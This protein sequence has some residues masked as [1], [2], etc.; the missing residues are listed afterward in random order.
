MRRG[1]IHC[2]VRG[3][4]QSRVRIPLPTCQNEG[5]PTR[6][7]DPNQTIIS[8]NARLPKGNPPP[9]LWP[10]AAGCEGAG[11]RGWGLTPSPALRR[12][13]VLVPA[14]RSRPG[15]AISLSLRNQRARGKPGAGCTRRSRAPEH[16]GIPYAEAHGRRLQ[17]QPRHPGLPRAMAL[18]LIRALPGER[19]LLS[20]LPGPHRQAG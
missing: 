4:V 20:P 6:R 14:A 12:I 5:F 19:P 9:E 3:P 18:R 7:C 2:V 16:T 15:C 17:V 13:R 11:N 10:Q 1:S 8:V